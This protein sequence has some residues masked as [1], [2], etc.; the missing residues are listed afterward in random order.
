MKNLKWCPK[1]AIPLCVHWF[2]TKHDHIV[3]STP[4]GDPPPVPACKGLGNRAIFLQF[5]DLGETFM[6]DPKY[7]EGMF[8]EAHA[9]EIVRFVKATP[10][11][12]LIV[13]NCEG[14][15]ARSPGVVLALRRH[16]GGDTEDIFEKAVPN[17]FVTSILSRVLRE[18]EARG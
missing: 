3:I 4:N 8:T 16:Y 18:E 17:I 7:R 2:G 12:T 14:G 13:V 11:E 6:H 15:V 1:I 9:R 5:H 10:D